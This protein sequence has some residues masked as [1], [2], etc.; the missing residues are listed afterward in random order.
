MRSRAWSKILGQVSLPGKDTALELASQSLENSTLKTYGWSFKLFKQYC[1]RE[2]RTWVEVATSTGGVACFAG[3]LMEKGYKPVT[4]PSIL[5]AIHRAVQDS[6]LNKPKHVLLT[7]INVAL[8][9][10]AGKTS[11]LRA[12]LKSTTVLRIMKDCDRLRLQRMTRS[13]AAEQ[14][15]VRA[16]IQSGLAVTLGFV[17]MLRRS[18]IKAMLRRDIQFSDDGDLQVFLR[19]EKGKMVRRSL[20]VRGPVAEWVAR[21]LDY[22]PED[23][24][25]HLFADAQEIYGADVQGMLSS[26]LDQLEVRPPPGLIWAWHSLRKGGATAAHHSGV[27]T[28]ILQHFGGWKGTESLT[29]SYIDF[30]H[31]R[32]PEDR[33]LMG[34]LQPDG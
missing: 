32:V 13:R 24:S 30:T 21:V 4:I 15:Q 29:Q 18:S 28:I 12:P 8:K 10:I 6:G 33:F 9:K 1:E 3:Y 34:F 26:W 19:F 22:L 7:S 5:S 23:Q 17:L 25:S 31:L 11:N 14:Q 16:Q 27:Q 20:T 2:G